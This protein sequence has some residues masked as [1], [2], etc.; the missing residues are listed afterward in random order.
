MS[1]HSLSNQELS[2]TNTKTS[3]MKISTIIYPL[4]AKKI[5]GM[6]RGN[7][8]IALMLFLFASLTQFKANAAAS[9]PA[10]TIT[11]NEVYCVNQ[12]VIINITIS[13]LTNFPNPIVLGTHIVYTFTNN[14][15]ATASATAGAFVYDG[16]NQAATV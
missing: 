5:F 6:I 13:N 12:T 7:I 1:T 14:N 4:T 9:P 8:K 2:S 11:G 3:I 10:C 16:L 15:G